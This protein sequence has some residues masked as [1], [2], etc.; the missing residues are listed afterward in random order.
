MA[1][2]KSIGQDPLDW[3]GDPGS[4]TKPKGGVSGEESGI[5]RKKSSIG[6]REGR[7]ANGESSRLEPPDM[8]SLENSS[9]ALHL[10]RQL[11]M[12]DSYIREESKRPRLNQLLWVLLLFL[13]FTGAAIILFQEARFQWRERV[14]NLEGAIQRV[15]NQKGHNERLLEQVIHEKDEVIRQ[16]QNT[17]RSLES[18]HES[19]TEELSIARTETHKLQSANHTLLERFIQERTAPRPSGDS[20]PANPSDS[21]SSVPTEARSDKTPG[22]NTTANTNANSTNE[23][24]AV[25]GKAG[26]IE[27]AP[28]GVVGEIPAVPGG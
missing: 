21:P 9:N 5:Y 19:T 24:A 27:K 14:A 17:I 6:G 12:A 22:E 7:D 13:T 20:A 3:I 15:E 2:R 23:K 10:E 25:K 8:L 1:K 16:K 4:L 18:I 28:S 26:K 11:L